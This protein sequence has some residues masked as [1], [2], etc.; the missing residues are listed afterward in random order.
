MN[1][2]SSAITLNGCALPQRICSLGTVHLSCT[3]TSH[4]P[5]ILYITISTLFPR[6]FR[7][8]FAGKLCV[9]FCCT[10]ITF[11]LVLTFVYYLIFISTYIFTIAPSL[12]YLFSHYRS[13]SCN[14][15]PCYLTFTHIFSSS[16][17]SPTN[18]FP[19]QL[20]D[21]AS[22]STFYT[23]IEKPQNKIPPSKQIK[24]SGLVLLL[25]AA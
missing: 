6:L 16:H 13:L 7:F 19:R 23:N 10:K 9:V 2:K 25:R 4:L 11:K 12:P 24:L 20:T 3:F 8:T 18:T 14:I 15:S 22:T 21:I 5:S 1:I 17:P